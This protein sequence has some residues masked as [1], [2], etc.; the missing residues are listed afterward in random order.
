[1]ASIIVPIAAAGIDI[2]A[3]L[4]AQLAETEIQKAEAYFPA[5]SGAYKIA[6]VAGNVLNWLKALG[7]AGQIQQ[8]PPE[9]DQLQTV[10]EGILASMQGIPGLMPAPGSGAAGLAALNAPASGSG[11]LEG[12]GMAQAILGAILKQAA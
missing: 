7:T 8:A 3:P 9:P 11:V 1:M 12:V 10:L 5:G 2:L 4:I 6:L